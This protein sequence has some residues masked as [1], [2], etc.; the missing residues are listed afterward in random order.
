MSAI[1]FW[2]TVAI[3]AI[4][5][6]SAAVWLLRRHF[7]ADD[8]DPTAQVFTLQDLRDM[9]ARGDLS[10]AEFDSMR[11]ALIQ[12]ARSRPTG[13]PAAPHK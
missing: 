5:A 10:E 6:M 11:A 3:G 8:S 2:G 1:F 9:R 4:L 12:Q 7:L 13:R